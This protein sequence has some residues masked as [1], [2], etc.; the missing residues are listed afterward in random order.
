MRD[1]QTGVRAASA[2]QVADDEVLRRLRREP[3][4]IEVLW[5][6]YAQN[7]FRYLS[8]RVGYAAAEDL[9]SD[10]FV[11]AL[12]SQKRVVAH[13]S[14]SALP[15][16]Y[17]IARNIVRHHFRALN[18]DRPLPFADTAGFDWANVDARLDAQSQRA[19]LRAALAALSDIER[20][21]LLLVAWEELTPTEAAKAL[22]ITSLAA[23]SR[24]H[25]ARRRAQHAFESEPD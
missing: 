3:A 8:R 15:W 6:R 10:V 2:D 19:R 4:L 5:A 24:L 17:G 1:F 22:G 9:L 14:A 23:R 25:R 21:L 16:L 7:I 12:D 11:A 18:T 13:E 20:E